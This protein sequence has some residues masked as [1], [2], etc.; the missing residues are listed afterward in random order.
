MK[1]WTLSLLALAAIMTSSCGSTTSGTAESSSAVAPAPAPETDLHGQWKSRIQKS[2]PQWQAP[3]AVIPEGSPSYS[4]PATP[5]PAVPEPPGFFTGGSMPAAVVQTPSEPKIYIV[6]DGDS[7]WSISKAAYGKGEKW[8]SIYEANKGK[9]K[10][11]DK[12]SPGVELTLP[13]Q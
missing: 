7:L 12:L 11:P 5:S 8:P 1:P 6:K 10:D 4:A 2:Y 13:A 9:L 3:S